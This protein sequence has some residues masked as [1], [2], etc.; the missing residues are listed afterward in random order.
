MGIVATAQLILYNDTER[1]SVRIDGHH[2]YITWTTNDGRITVSSGDAEAL[3]RVSE[4][5]ASAA[6]LVDTDPT[7]PEVA[8]TLAIATNGGAA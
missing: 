3:R 1:P 5:F 6:R 7:D 2:A 4:A 8:R